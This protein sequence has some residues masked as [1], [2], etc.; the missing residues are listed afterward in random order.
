MIYYSTTNSYVN[1]SINSVSLE[2]S[3][4]SYF[5]IHYNH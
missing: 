1:Y 5:A 3:K 2:N 4:N